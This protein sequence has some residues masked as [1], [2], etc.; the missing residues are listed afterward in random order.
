MS[1][2]RVT[3]R[4]DGRRRS[5]QPGDDLAGQ[6]RVEAAE[7]AEI[8]AIELSVLWH[9]EGKGDEDLGVH[10]FQ[11]L[12]ADEDNAFDLR[13]PARF[14]TRLPQSPLSYDGRL[15]KIRWCVRVRVFLDGGESLIEEL[16]FQLGSVPPPPRM[17]EP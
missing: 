11:R 6:C 14:S 17:D 15:I 13:A 2:P 9:T 12:A 16:P 8:K 7:A 3:V 10:F 1:V 4:L 5:Y